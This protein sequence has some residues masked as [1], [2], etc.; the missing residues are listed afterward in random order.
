MTVFEESRQKSNSGFVRFRNDQ[1]HQVNF[2][3]QYVGI[4][5]RMELSYSAGF[6][7]GQVCELRGAI[8][9]INR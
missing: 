1:Q 7:S 6:F 4:S 3:L 2:E 5:L 8:D 9:F